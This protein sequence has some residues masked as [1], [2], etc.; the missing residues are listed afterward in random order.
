MHMKESGMVE[1]GNRET[2]AKNDRFEIRE[3]RMGWVSSPS[4]Q[5]DCATVIANKRPWTDAIA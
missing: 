1:Q 3:S 2:M 5:R 4:Q